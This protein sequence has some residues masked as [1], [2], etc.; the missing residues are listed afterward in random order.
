MLC[1]CHSKLFF[2]LLLSY[3]MV[4][5]PLPET[6]YTTSSRA[7]FRGGV[8]SP[9]G[10]S[11]TRLELTPSEPSNWIKADRHWRSSHQPSSTVL[12][13]STKKP[14]WIGTPVDSIQ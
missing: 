10:I 3:Q 5:R 11:V 6:T 2:A 4:L 13:S 9:A 14:L 8:V 7:N 12:R 1:C